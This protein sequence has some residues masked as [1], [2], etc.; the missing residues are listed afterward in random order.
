MTAE[1][2]TSGRSDES[3]SWQDW[4]G[5][6]NR[7]P[8]HPRTDLPLTEATLD[9]L[10]AWQ[11]EL[12]ARDP[13]APTEHYALRLRPQEEPPEPDPAPPRDGSSDLADRLVVE[14]FGTSTPTGPDMPLTDVVAMLRSKVAPGV[15]RLVGAMIEGDRYART[16]DPTPAVIRAVLAMWESDADA[17]PMDSPE[18]AALIHR[19][20]Q[21]RAALAGAAPGRPHPGA[22]NIDVDS[23]GHPDDNET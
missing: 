6:V 12:L 8:N 4:T 10:R 9:R 5:L 13:S 11:Q 19:T 2:P 17:L 16:G 3:P 14:A 20:D 18:R 15:V 23:M 1:P 22:A 21:I 7:P